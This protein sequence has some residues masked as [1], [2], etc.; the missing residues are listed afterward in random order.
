[1]RCCVVSMTFTWRI[2]LL[3]VVNNRSIRRWMLSQ[4]IPPV[5]FTLCSKYPFTQCGNSNLITFH[6]ADCKDI[7]VFLQRPWN[8]SETLSE[9]MLQKPQHTQTHTHTHT[10]THTQP[11]T[12]HNSC[13]WCSSTAQF[14][15][16]NPQRDANVQLLF[17]ALEQSYTEQGHV[18]SQ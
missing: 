3:F 13:L 5:A 4:K 11:V 16:T 18:W 1:M 8:S 15:G 10:H 12:V 9:V 2:F 7:L 6:K 17:I 14:S